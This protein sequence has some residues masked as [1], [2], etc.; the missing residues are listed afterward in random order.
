MG[1]HF[2][3]RLGNKVLPVVSPQPFGLKASGTEAGSERLIATANEQ[4]R[5]LFY[6]KSFVWEGNLRLLLED[7]YEK[8]NKLVASGEYLEAKALVYP[9]SVD[10]QVF[11]DEFIREANNV[12]KRG[13]LTTQYMS[14]AMWAVSPELCLTTLKL[15]DSPYG[16]A[17]VFVTPPIVNRQNGLFSPFGETDFFELQPTAQQADCVLV[18]KDGG[19][20]L[21]LAKFANLEVVELKGARADHVL[22]DGDRGY[23]TVLQG[24][25]GVEVESLLGEVDQ[26]YQKLARMSKALLDKHNDFKPFF[27]SIG[28]QHK[29][30]AE[31]VLSQSLLQMAATESIP[32]NFA[33]CVAMTSQHSYKDVVEVLAKSAKGLVKKRKTEKRVVESVDEDGEVATATLSDWRHVTKGE[34]ALALK[35]YVYNMALTLDDTFNDTLLQSAMTELLSAQD[36][37]SLRLT[38]SALY[39]A[40]YAKNNA[41]AD[42]FKEQA[43]NFLA[44]QSLKALLRHH[45]AVVW[46]SRVCDSLI[47]SNSISKWAATE[48]KSSEQFMN[49]VMAVLGREAD[50]QQKT[51]L[52]LVPLPEKQRFEIDATAT[53]YPVSSIRIE[54]SSQEGYMKVT[55]VQKSDNA[56]KSGSTIV[57]DVLIRQDGD[58]EIVKKPAEAFFKRFGIGIRAEYNGQVVTMEDAATKKARA[59]YE[60]KFQ[61]EWERTQGQ[62]DD[63]ERL[64]DFEKPKSSG[65]EIDYKP[66]HQIATQDETTE[67]WSGDSALPTLRKV[68]LQGGIVAIVQKVKT[69]TSEQVAELKDELN[70]KHGNIEKRIAERVYAQ[71]K[72]E[73]KKSPVKPTLKD[74]DLGLDL[75]TL[76]HPALGAI[77][78]ELDGSLDVDS[79]SRDQLVSS[80]KD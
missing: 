44:K 69:L 51:R 30:L 48:P 9:A 55:V 61:A 39:A 42:N 56:L 24:N 28:S 2:N 58:G 7:E 68:G 34:D 1:K 40:L 8:Y 62:L 31:K 45:D 25:T 19:Y 16:N 65:K 15:L 41:I 37:D 5:K 50:F 46:V 64:W 79:M 29:T 70:V 52:T 53:N 66:K 43:V 75:S 13:A 23:N 77:V 14:V 76:S 27:S 38:L 57:E 60:A 17:G 59:D 74:V 10:E 35:V 73:Y 3:D 80:L 11:L 20:S 21:K 78:A 32:S 6:A 63:H 26:S 33:F 49:D 71:V 67:A 47:A 18:Q 54:A 72:S 22:T 4:Y 12:L 36:D